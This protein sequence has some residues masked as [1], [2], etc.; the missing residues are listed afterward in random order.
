MWLEL[1]LLT[2]TRDRVL[3]HRRLLRSLGW[4]D[5]DYFGNVVEIVPHL[6]GEPRNPAR[7]RPALGFPNFDVVEDFLD[8]VGA[9]N[10]RDQAIF[11]NHAP[12][13][14]A[15][16]DPELIEIRDAVGQLP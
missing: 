10:L 15:P 16:L 3:A 1:A 14:I 9:E 8:L 6:L 2:G 7:G 13:A 12:G 5:A 11:V 4:R